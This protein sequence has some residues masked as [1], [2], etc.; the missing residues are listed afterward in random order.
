MSDMNRREALTL[1]AL[2]P[3]AATVRAVPRASAAE[4]AVELAAAEPLFFTPHELATVSM[5]ADIIIPAD[6]RSGSATQAGVPAYIDYL[7]SDEVGRSSGLAIRGG[8][9]WLDAESQKRFQ[10]DFIDLQDAQ[11]TAILDDIAWPE[12]AKPEMSH[13]VAFFNRF[14]D[15]VGSGFFSSKMGVE[16]LRYQGNSVVM[17]WKGCP[18]EALKKLGVS[19]PT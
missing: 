14:R 11:R 10:H 8:L 15:L 2:S 9:A 17:E 6:E 13:G 1:L 18:P 12:R 4:V 7:L 16:D 19:Y 3:L 5:L